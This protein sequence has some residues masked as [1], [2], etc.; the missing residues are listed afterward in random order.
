[1]PGQTDE[2]KHLEPAERLDVLCRKPEDQWLERKSS[3]IQARDV[4]E[5]LVAFANAEGGLLVI[6]LSNKAVEGLEGADENAFRQAARDFTDPP[7]RHS[8]EL[9]PVVTAAGRPDRIALIEIEASDLVH[10]TRA[11]DVFLRVGDEKRKLREFEVRELEYDKGQSSFDGRPVAGARLDDL[12]DGLMNRYFASLQPHQPGFD[13]LE[14]RGLVVRT[15]EGL[16][17]TTA[18]V[19][20]L[21]K[22]P[23]R[24]FPEAWLRVLEYRGRSR[25]LGVAANVVADHRFEGSLTEQLGEARAYLKRT[26]ATAIRIGSAGRF[27]SVPLIPEQAWQEAVTNAII[28]RSYSMSGDHIRVELFDDRLEVESPGRLP[29]LVR[30]ENIRS[31]RFARNPRIARAMADLGY[32]REL[33]EGVDRMFEEMERAGLSDPIYEQRPASVRVSLIA[34]PELARV[35]ASLP[36]WLARV[37]EAIDRTS[38]QATTTGLMGLLGGSRP[39]MLKHLYALEKRGLVERVGSAHDPRG[40]WRLP[41]KSSR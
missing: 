37:L 27:Q 33:G 36:P 26:I 9:L 29:G 22:S 20:V 17:P 32:G 25:V 39:T 15:G 19:L 16:V 10:R 28:H 4:G 40:Y 3:R 24:F 30:I 38:G 5:A 21:T 11:G 6:G 41:V 2:L 7:V 35:L 1:M 18:G 12:D 8:F 31:T 23:Q 13:V 34:D 14:A